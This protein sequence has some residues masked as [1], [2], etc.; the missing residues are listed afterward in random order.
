MQ[1][2]DFG[3]RLS[4]LELGPW[5]GQMVSRAVYLTRGWQG[6]KIPALIVLLLVLL[7]LPLLLLL[8]VL[9]LLICQLSIE[10]QNNH[11]LFCFYPT[12][13]VTLVHFTLEQKWIYSSHSGCDRHPTQKKL[14]NAGILIKSAII[15]QSLIG[16]NPLCPEPSQQ[17]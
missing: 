11:Q 13:R 7:L 10:P 9:L 4:G 3:A 12:T 2:W 5:A 8:L 16:S 14:A 1:W 17:W 6:C 15:F